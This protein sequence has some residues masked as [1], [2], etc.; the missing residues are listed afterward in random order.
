MSMDRIEGNWKQFQGSLKE[1]WGRITSNKSTVMAGVR[2]RLEGSLQTRHAYGTHPSHAA[3]RL[4]EAGRW[5]KL[6]AGVETAFRDLRALLEPAEPLDG[7][8]TSVKLKR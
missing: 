3:V 7:G 6:N 4:I 5:K 8:T 1:K 2:E